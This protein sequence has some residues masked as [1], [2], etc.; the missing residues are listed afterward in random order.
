DH[1]GADHL[2]HGGRAAEPAADGGR[3]DCCAARGPCLLP[4]AEAVHRRDCTQRY[5]GIAGHQSGPVTIKEQTM[6]RAKKVST[7]AAVVLLFSLPLWAQGK[8]IAGVDPRGVTI[9]YWYQHSG[10]NGDAMQKMI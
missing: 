2:H 9:S 1:R 4:G 6:R 8:S 7:L 3:G 10:V 5:Q